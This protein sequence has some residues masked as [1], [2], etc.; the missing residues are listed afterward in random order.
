A[1]CRL[2]I[3][4]D[5]EYRQQVGDLEHATDAAAR[6]EQ[7]QRA[8]SARDVKQHRDERARAAAV[9]VGDV[10]EVD[11]DVNPSSGHRRGDLLPQLRVVLVGYQPP[12]QSEDEDVGDDLV[13]DIER[14]LFALRRG[15][16]RTTGQY[17]PNCGP[18]PGGGARSA[19]RGAGDVRGWTSERRPAPS[20]A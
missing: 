12:G 18:S 14:H 19:S 2:F 20:G 7:L 11:E 15:R 9:H 16:R 8:S 3:L 6:A 1:E 13:G 10:V 17:T 4:E 5:I